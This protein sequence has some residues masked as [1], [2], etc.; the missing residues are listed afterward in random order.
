MIA[1]SKFAFLRP[2]LLLMLLSVLLVGCRSGDRAM[3]HLWGH[4]HER[5]L[6]DGMARP[7]IEEATAGTTI[8]LY[9]FSD[10][11]S[12]ALPGFAEGEASRGG[13]ARVIGLLEEVKAGQENVL[14]FSGGDMMNLNNP[15]WSDV[16]TCT[17]WSWFNGLI[18]GM[19]LGNHEFDYGADL[20]TDCTNNITYPLISSGLIYSETQESLLPEYEI[21]EVEGV[22]VGVFAVAGDDYPR[23]VRPELIPAGTRW[24]VGE[25]KL[26]RAAEIVETLRVTETADITLSI[27]HQSREEDEAMAR[28]I[29]GID[30]ILGTH[31]HLKV[32]L[33]QIEGTETYFISPFQY[34]DYVSHVVLQIEDG[35][36]VGIT[37][38]LIA[39]NEET[40][41][42]EL[43]AD[44]I[45]TMQEALE[46]EHPERFEVL[47]E[48]AVLID[49]SDINLGETG[50]G[51]FVTDL[52]RAAV[53]AHLFLSTS[54][55]FRA[56]L[57]PGPITQEA[58]LTALPYSN[59]IVT[60][61]LRGEQIEEL[62]TVSAAKR[63][64]DLFS[65]MGGVRYTLHAEDN[66]VSEIQ[67]LTDPTDPSAGYS[68]LDPEANYLVATT[69]YQALIAADYKDIF[70][71]AEDVTDT[72]ININELVIEEIREN[73][74]V[75][76]GVDGRLLI[77]EA[78]SDSE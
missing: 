12:H 29:P 2:L 73:S 67:L 42:E 5:H 58:Y 34:L 64:G 25:E 15:I 49:N 65:Q 27:G 68:D 38:D 45:E 39:I 19:A 41:A 47:G 21:Y 36:L 6:E 50:I 17:E 74:P 62:L 13:I 28:A 43:L 63:G 54:S 8:E 33:M 23:I 51:N 72:A 4:M 48:A 3:R 9:H 24:L 35:A 55:S 10:Y 77:V 20:F 40:P 69:N 57:P 75:S 44:K 46:E 78:S 56:A 1:R 18:D 71:V 14:A 70:A 7:Q 16:Y 26:A 32:P 53:D 37:G 11:H 30:L 52:A 22:R 61:T 59:T 60:A 31:S 66:S 76:A